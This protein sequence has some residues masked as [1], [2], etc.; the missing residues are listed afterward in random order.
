MV[1][2]LA[3]ALQFR[4]VTCAVMYFGNES[5]VGRRGVGGKEE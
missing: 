3:N 1:G 4:H 2:R 5:E